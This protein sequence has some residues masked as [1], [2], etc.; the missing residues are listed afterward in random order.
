MFCDFNL[1]YFAKLVQIVRHFAS[2]TFLP[3][4]TCVVWT[5]EMLMIALKSAPIVQRY[6]KL[7][8]KMPGVL[9][10]SY[11]LCLVFQWY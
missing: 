11:V 1:N 2:P 10:Y 9:N 3:A 6:F 4:H 7:N 5:G 8:C